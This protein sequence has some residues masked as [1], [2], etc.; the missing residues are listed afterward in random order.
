[1][2]EWLGLADVSVAELRYRLGEALEL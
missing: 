1:L 2:M